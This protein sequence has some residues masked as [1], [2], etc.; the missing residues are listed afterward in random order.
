MEIQFPELP[1]YRGWGKPLR[2]ESSIDGLELL[3]GKTPEGLNGT[4]YRVGPDRQYPPMNGEDVF[5]DGEGMIHMIRFADG[6]ASYKSRWVHTE[7]F[8]RQAEAKRSLFG[9]YRNTYTND[10]SVAGVHMG[11]GNTNAIYHAGKLLV[12]KEDDLPYELD[13]DTLETF[14]RYDYDGQIGANRL[15]AHP[16]IDLVNN[17]VLTFS[18][19]ARG[20]GSEDVVFYEIDGS[21]KV[22]DEIWFKGPYAASLHDFAVTENYVIFPF[23]PLITDVEALKKGGRFYQWHPD[24]ET[25]IAVVKRGGTADDVRFFRGSAMSAGHMM[26]AYEEGSRLHLDL[27]LYHGNC[28]PFFATPDGVH[29]APV[30]PV[31]TRLTVDMAQNDEAFALAPIGAISGEMPRTDDRWQGFPYK[32][33]WLITGRGPNGESNL[34]HVDVSTGK[35]TVWSPGEK[36]SIH[37]PQFVPRSDDSPEGDGWILAIVNR[38]D[39]NRGEL[40]VLDALDIAKGPVATY[41]LPVRV[42]STFHGTWVPGHVF[43]TK[44]YNMKMVPAA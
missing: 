10:P 7:R 12:L 2:V 5:I 38:L 26:N 15:S 36:A 35:L 3:S 32:H 21:G 30:P 29:T 1:L 43:E 4:W 41:A 18:G 31:L 22:I 19:H 17:N 27:C 16:K 14:R 13:P 37:E 40:A 11:T 42:R 34:G 8:K 25:V 28:F 9:R 20:D 23:F 24:K 6:Q 39:E 33:G 44:Q